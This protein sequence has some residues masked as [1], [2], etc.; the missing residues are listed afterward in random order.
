MSAPAKADQAVQ[1][2][3]DQP[4]QAAAKPAARRPAMFRRRSYAARQTPEQSRRQSVLVQSAWR[5]F[6]ESGPMIAFLNT[7]HEALGAQ[8]LHL[9]LESDE[10]LE[11]VERLLHQLTLEG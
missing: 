11:R 3:G 8:P 10:G 9:A 2:E 1:P 4:G 5:H 6:R 7:T